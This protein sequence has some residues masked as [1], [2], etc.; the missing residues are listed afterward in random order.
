MEKKLGRPKK[1][2]VKDKVVSVR[3]KPDDY[4]RFKKYADAS[5]STISKLMQEGIELVIEKHNH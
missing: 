1:E 3:L 2:V 5:N 4:E